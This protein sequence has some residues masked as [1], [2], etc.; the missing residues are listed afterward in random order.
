MILRVGTPVATTQGAISTTISI[1]YSPVPGNF[2]SVF[3]WGSLGSAMVVGVADDGAAGGSVYLPAINLGTAQ[4]SRTLAIFYTKSAAVGVANITATVPGSQKCAIL[5]SEY[6]GIQSSTDPLDATSVM[7]NGSSASATTISISPSPGDLE[8]AFFYNFNNT[9]PWTT[10]AP[11]SGVISLSDIDGEKLQVSDQLGANT[12]TANATQGS[13]VSWSCI[14]AT[15]KASS[16]VT[17]V[18]PLMPQA[19][20]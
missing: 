17:V 3:V 1:A 8:L 20:M 19:C 15:F 4:G 7:S 2:V 9:N 12:P 18:P 10:S 13:S 6:S 16:T 5:I 14:M 11:F